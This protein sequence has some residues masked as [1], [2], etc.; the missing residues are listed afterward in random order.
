MSVAELPTLLETMRLEGGEPRHLNQHL[1]RLAASAQHF[2]LPFDEQEVR[3]RIAG[4]VANIEEGS[5][6]AGPQRLRVLLSEKGMHAEVTPLGPNPDPVRVH[7]AREAVDSRNIFLQHKTARR[8]LYLPH[9]AHLPAGEDALLFNERG[10]LTEFTTGNL[11]LLLD[12]EYLTPAL[13]CGLLPGVGRRL[14]LGQG[15]IQEAVLHVSDLA[16]AAGLWHL[17][18]LRG[19][20]RAELT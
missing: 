8:D 9:T 11:V 2:G 14:A 6:Y 1:E 4:A 7:L 19:W 15:E 20:R 10:E 16:Q 18:S 17:N 13:T 5:D 12:G 3:R